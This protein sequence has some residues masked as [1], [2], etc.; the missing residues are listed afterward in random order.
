MSF[1]KSLKAG[2]K[3]GKERKPICSLSKM[4]MK[5]RFPI[6]S[7]K[8]TFGNFREQIMLELEHCI[9]YLPQRYNEKFSDEDI[10]NM[11]KCYFEVVAPFGNSSFQVDFHVKQEFEEEL[12]EEQ[13][14]APQQ[15]QQQQL[16]Q[17]QL[18]P[19]NMDEVASTSDHA[20]QIQQQQQQQQQQL[21]SS[22]RQRTRKQKHQ[23]EVLINPNLFFD[24]QNNLLNS[25]KMFFK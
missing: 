14:V 17:L 7:A 25:Q 9:A 13:E 10:S 11:P 24:D 1:I 6:T 12:E 23:E 16:P 4:P 18:Q 20:Q 19:L 2:C 8:R 21:Q 3:A 15:Q 5:N 22:H